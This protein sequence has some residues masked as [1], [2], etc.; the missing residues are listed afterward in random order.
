MLELLAEIEGVGA[1]LAVIGVAALVVLRLALC[2][3]AAR[4]PWR[5]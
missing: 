3:L 5:S 4:W 1:L 2:H